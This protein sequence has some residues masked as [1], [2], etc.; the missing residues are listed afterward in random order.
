MLK[1]WKKKPPDADKADAQAEAHADETTLAP[2]ESPVDAAATP[3][4]PDVDDAAAEAPPTRRSWRERLS[5]SGFARGLAS[6][7]KR[8]PVLDDAFL[9]E[10]ETCLITADVG[11]ATASE[12]VEDLRDRVGKREFADATA[13]LS[14][15]RADLVARLSKVERPLDVGARAPFVLLMVGVNGVGKTTTIG[16]LAYYWRRQGKNVL[17]GAADTFRAAAVDQIDIWA[18][19]A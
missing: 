7:F 15:L 14:A 16:K 1:F 8:N 3:S 18:Q 9:D 19:R 11:V 13:L 2:V 10:L 12:I 6:I 5:G 4:V 17:L